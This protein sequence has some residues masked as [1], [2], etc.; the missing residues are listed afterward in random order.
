[1]VTLFHLARHTN[2]TAGTGILLHI[3]SK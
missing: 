1:V 3:I 2:S